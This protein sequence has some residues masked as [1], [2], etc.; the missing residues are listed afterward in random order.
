[1]VSIFVFE[2]SE[3]YPDNVAVDSNWKAARA[4]A[5]LVLIIGGIL[6]LNRLYILFVFPDKRI[7]TIIEVVGYLCC[8]L[9]Q[10][11][12]LLFLKSDA[13]NDN[14]L[15]KGLGV[16]FSD[17]CSMGVGAKCVIAASVF[18]FLAAVHSHP[19]EAMQ[20]HPGELDQG[21]PPAEIAQEEQE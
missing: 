11:L 15:M 7:P 4:F 5:T 8:S 14:F 21:G 2:T 13:C 17:T 3:Y 9:F 20:V 6:V 1:M 10:G 12:S 16:Y 19:A 18:W